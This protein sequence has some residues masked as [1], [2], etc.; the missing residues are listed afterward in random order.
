MRMKSMTILFIAV[1]T[2]LTACAGESA[3]ADSRATVVEIALS[4]FTNLPDSGWAV[5]T[6]PTSVNEGLVSLKVKNINTAATQ[7]DQPDIPHNLLI[8]KTDLPPDQL[9]RLGPGLG[10]DVNEVDVWGLVPTLNSE[11]ETTLGLPMGEGNYV[12][13]CNIN[14]NGVDFSAH[15]EDGMYTGFVVTGN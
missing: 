8:I 15:Y 4:D 13:V 2:V 10:V 7:A 3:K 9:P 11:E 14:P 6:S 5:I 1:V 12:L